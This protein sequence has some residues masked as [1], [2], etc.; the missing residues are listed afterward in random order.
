MKRL[1]QPATVQDTLRR[2]EA[3]MAED[4]P[5]WGTIGVAHVV[6]HL[7]DACEIAMGMADAGPFTPTWLSS[8]PG[9][10]LIIDS[11]L[12]WPKGKIKALAAFHRSQPSQFAA[13]RQKLLDLVARHG[14]HPGPWAV[15][16]AFGALSPRRWQRLQWRHLDH[17]LRQFGR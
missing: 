17:H 5:R 15:S 7:A 3:L 10:W 6:C 14:V 2:I 1:D 11:P 8:W 12:P 9:L 16:P 13:D 4:Q